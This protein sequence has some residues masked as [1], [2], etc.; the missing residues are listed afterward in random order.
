MCHL[1][2]NKL[3]IQFKAHV[4][5]NYE[6]WFQISKLYRINNYFCTSIEK[7]HELIET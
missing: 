3:Q 5:F 1:D 4:F 6:V 2:K 7:K